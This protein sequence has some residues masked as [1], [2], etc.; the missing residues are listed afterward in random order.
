[1]SDKAADDIIRVLAL[2]WRGVDKT[3]SREAI[4]R[5]WSLDLQWLKP[6]E[7]EAAVE[8][9]LESHWLKKEENGLSPNPTLRNISAPL[10]WF[11]RP[12]ILLHPP[13]FRMPNENIQESVKTTAKSPILDDIKKQPVDIIAD[14]TGLVKE[15]VLRRAKRK[16][17]ALGCVEDWFCL[18]LVARE[19]GIAVK[20]LIESL[21]D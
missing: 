3:L 12:S 1:M 10:G 11:P 9:L 20:P 5:S 13:P 17:R 2:T 14:I 16:K 21:R 7:A 8:Q 15:E 6:D 18:A 19:Q 4:A